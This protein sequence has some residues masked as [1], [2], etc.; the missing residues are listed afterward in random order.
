MS[1][2]ERFF[3]DERVGCIA[4][5]DRLEIDPEN[6]CLE[7]GTAGVVRYWDA[8]HVDLPCCPTCG[9]WPGKTW[10]L[11]PETVAQANA[12]AAHLNAGN[13]LESFQS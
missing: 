5:L 9:H 11:S 10:K 7:S 13:S 8:D 2:N 1:D 6:R 4:V 12:L 3:V